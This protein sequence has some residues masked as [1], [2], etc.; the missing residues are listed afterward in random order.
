MTPHPTCR[1]HVWSM[2]GATVAQCLPAASI[3]SIR[4]QLRHDY[5]ASTV[6]RV[7]AEVIKSFAWINIFPDRS[8]RVV[9]NKTRSNPSKFLFNFTPHISDRKP[10]RA[11]TFFLHIQFLRLQNTEDL[12]KKKKD[13][14]KMIDLDDSH[15]FQ[16]AASF[17]SS[18]TTHNLSACFYVI[19]SFR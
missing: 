7:L 12:Q 15:L 14:K 13:K 1:S 17:K 6:F 9:H 16:L 19:L 2:W 8:P 3:S 11:N 4:H 18:R 10:A 5:L